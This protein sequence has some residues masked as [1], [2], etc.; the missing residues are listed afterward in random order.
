[1]AVSDGQ[2]WSDGEAHDQKGATRMSPQSASYFA[3]SNY[4]ELYLAVE[5]RPPSTLTCSR[6]SSMSDMTREARDDFS[7]GMAWGNDDGSVRQ[8]ASENLRQES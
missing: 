5:C 4:L 3:P 7:A 2:N 8:G 1:M 6:R